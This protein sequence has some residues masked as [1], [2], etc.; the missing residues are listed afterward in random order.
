MLLADGFFL[1]NRIDTPDGSRDLSG[2]AAPL[3][4]GQPIDEESQ[5][6]EGSKVT[7]ALDPDHRRHR[8][9][10]RWALAAVT[11]AALF[12]GAVSSNR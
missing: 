3:V 12:L 5:V 6:E 1:G 2:D 4:T 11:G 7:Q 10:A 8:I 9:S